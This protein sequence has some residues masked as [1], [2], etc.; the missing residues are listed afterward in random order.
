MLHGAGHVAEGERVLWGADIV[1]RTG[2][3]RRL[4]DFRN[5]DFFRFWQI[6]QLFGIFW[7]TFGHSF[8]K[9]F[10]SFEGLPEN[11]GF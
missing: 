11:S 10:K 5:Y 8:R 3:R 6:L 9:I 4:L 7:V 1:G 2:I